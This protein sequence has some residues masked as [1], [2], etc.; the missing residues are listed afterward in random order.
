MTELLPYHSPEDDVV[1]LRLMYGS[2]VSIRNWTRYSFN[3]NY[4]SPT[5]G[6]SFAVGDDEIPEVLKNGLVPGAL[7]QFTINGLVQGA[8]N[9]D[10]VTRNVTRSG[11][12]EWTINGRDVFGPVV[13]AHIDPRRQFK[14][15]MTLEQIV[16]EV[17]DGFNPAG[18]DWEYVWNADAN[19]KVKTGRA[20]GKGGKRQA[21]RQAKL[22]QMRP[23]VH[24][25]AYAFVSKLV[26]RQGLHVFPSADGAAVIVDYPSYDQE[27]LHTLVRTAEESNI[28]DGS[29]KWSCQDQPSVIIADGMSGGG[30]FGH[31]QV[32]AK[33]VNPFTGVDQNGMKWPEVKMV[34]DAYPSARELFFDSVTFGL[35]EF[36]WPQHFH[37]RPLF[38]HDENSQTAEELESFLRREMSLRVRRVLTVTYTVE[39]HGQYASD[40]SF[41]PYEVDTIVRVRDEPG[42][43]NTALWVLG[44]TFEKSRSGGTTTRLELIIP[45]SLQFG[46]S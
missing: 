35:K 32:M 34:C 20:R 4:E 24:E 5:D 36:R 30:E 33:M 41:V 23:G 42:G 44:R 14:K 13:D 1:E 16:Q 8:G 28:L 12:T 22:D 10:S 26:H 45:G 17:F 6:W 21:K 31:S 43:L 9:I 29:V 18:G 25:G 40:G 11:G 19:H 37:T 7:V 2:R 46:E 15:D 39:G 3:S 27:P 38:L